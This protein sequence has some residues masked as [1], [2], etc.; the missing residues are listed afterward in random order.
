MPTYLSFRGISNRILKAAAR[1]S[2]CTCW[3]ALEGDGLVLLVLLLAASACCR[4]PLFSVLAIIK[5]ICQL[6]RSWRCWL[7]T[8]TH[9]LMLAA[10]QQQFEAEPRTSDHTSTL[11]NFRNMLIFKN[12]TKERGALPIPR[13]S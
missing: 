9:L 6:F 11:N 4:A 12:K 5:F 2:S 3:L 1:R 10:V 13:N 7:G 8:K